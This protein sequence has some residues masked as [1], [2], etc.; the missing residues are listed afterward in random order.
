MHDAFLQQVAKYQADIDREFCKEHLLLKSFPTI[1][2]LPKSGAPPIKFPS[3]RRTVDA[4][5]MWV[6]TLASNA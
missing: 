3:E 2:L 1:I 5:R 4:M 6:K